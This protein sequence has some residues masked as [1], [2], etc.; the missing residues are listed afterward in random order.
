[1]DTL[2]LTLAKE[3]DKA[4]PKNTPLVQTVATFSL[5]FSL[6]NKQSCGGMSVT[7]H[8]EKVLLL[9]ILFYFR[10]GRNFSIIPH[11]IGINTSCYLDSQK[12]DVTFSCY[13]IYA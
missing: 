7:P 3:E 2:A 9:S 1:M 11:L 4:L 6:P 10:R 12:L 13:N 8:M 5:S